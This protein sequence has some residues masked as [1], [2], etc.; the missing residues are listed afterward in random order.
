MDSYLQYVLLKM[1]TSHLLNLLSCAECFRSIIG[2]NQL[3]WHARISNTS[4]DIEW[5]PKYGA[6]YTSL[7]CYDTDIGFYLITEHEIG[8][9]TTSG[10]GQNFHFFSLLVAVISHLQVRA[11]APHGMYESTL[12]F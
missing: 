7:D 4:T 5:D 6:P 12:C 8:H 1:S 10:S 11:I 2:F 9:K 3:Q